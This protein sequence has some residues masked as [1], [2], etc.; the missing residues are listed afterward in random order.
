[1]LQA[2][3]MNHQRRTEKCVPVENRTRDDPQFC[4]PTVETGVALG[5]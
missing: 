5:H 3:V 2:I 1:M 4:P